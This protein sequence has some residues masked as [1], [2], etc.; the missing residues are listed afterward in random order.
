[1]EEQSK[2]P[3]AEHPFYKGRVEM[4]SFVELG[5]HRRFLCRDILELS[6]GYAKIV[7][8]RKEDVRVVKGRCEHTDGKDEDPPIGP[9]LVLERSIERRPKEEQSSYDLDGA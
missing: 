2:Y 8:L 1:M 7:H 6:N 5:F 3:R 4:M 9:T